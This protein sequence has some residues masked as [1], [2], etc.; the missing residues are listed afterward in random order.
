MTCDRAFCISFGVWSVP[1][2][3]LRIR[4]ELAIWGRGSRAAHLYSVDPFGS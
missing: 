1:V 4:G 2:C 3:L